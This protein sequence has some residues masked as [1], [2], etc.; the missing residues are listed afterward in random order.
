[1]S[2]P[3]SLANVIRQFVSHSRRD[4]LDWRACRSF[5]SAATPDLLA[6]ARVSRAQ[7]QGELAS[8]SD[9]RFSTEQ[10]QT[11]P[12]S[13][14]ASFLASLDIAPYHIDKMAK[15]YPAILRA[16]PGDMQAN[17]D[18]LSRLGFSQRD[19]RVLWRGYPP[20]A[21][22][23]G[24]RNPIPR[25]ASLISWMRGY[26]VTQED[27]VCKI[28]WSPKVTT[29]SITN[30]LE[31][32]IRWVARTLGIPHADAAKVLLGDVH[33]LHGTQSTLKR[34]FDAA[35]SMGFTQKEL[36]S[37]CIRHPMFMEIGFHR[38]DTQRKMQ[39][40]REELGV[41]LVEAMRKN[42]SVFRFSLL[43]I[44]SRSIFARE[45]RATHPHVK[46]YGIHALVDMTPSKFLERMD[47]TPEEFEAWM[48]AWVKTPQALRWLEGTRYFNRPREKCWGK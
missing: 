1:M 45:R 42:P 8:A 30:R 13:P 26:G 18:A 23:T 4:D 12:A 25:I 46:T 43:R 29:T 34:I 47:A 15:A 14:A 35:L 38:L 32:N 40:M 21:Y 3:R 6:T 44:T 27:A 7:Q 33:K 48:D 41:D 2:Y 17:A 20:I 36:A 31:P 22:Q 11:P 10:A 19:V 16:D 5:A 24:N 9:L 37:I 39:F 28:R